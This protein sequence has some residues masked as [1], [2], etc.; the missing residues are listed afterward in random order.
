M[1]AIAVAV[2]VVGNGSSDGSIYISVSKFRQSAA[3]GHGRNSAN[4]LYKAWLKRRRRR[5]GALSPQLLLLLQ[6]EIMG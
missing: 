1:S 2:A 5:N 4:N 6:G 3:L